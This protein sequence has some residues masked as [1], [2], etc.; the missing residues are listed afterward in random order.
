M[1]VVKHETQSAVS[2]YIVFLCLLIWLKESVPHQPQTS[3]H[4]TVFV[5]K[6]DQVCW[7]HNI[8]RSLEQQRDTLQIGSGTVMLRR[9]HSSYLFSLCS[10]SSQ[11]SSSSTPGSFCTQTSH[12]CQ[13]KVVFATRSSAL[14]MLSYIDNL[15][16][17][18]DH[19]FFG[20]YLDPH[21]LYANLPS[22]FPDQCPSCLPLLSNS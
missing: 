13:I 18:P 14:C 5:N 6:I 4:A 9:C 2:K 17:P 16:F 22:C 11:L 15:C 21:L 20:W 7:W 1:S 8:G 10:M 3:L 12:L 19:K